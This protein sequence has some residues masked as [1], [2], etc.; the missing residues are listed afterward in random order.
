MG[1]NFTY[2]D[3]IETTRIPRFLGSGIRL[4]W[5]RWIH[6]DYGYIEHW[7]SIV[8]HLFYEREEGGVLSLMRGEGGVLSLMR[9]EGGGCYL[10]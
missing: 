1:Q 7:Y 10:S 4:Q 6:S 2:P 5:P 3:F 8:T 9:G